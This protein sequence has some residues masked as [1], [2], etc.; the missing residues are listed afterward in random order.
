MMNGPDYSDNCPDCGEP[1]AVHR[2]V[3]PLTATRY[4]ASCNWC[5]VTDGDRQA[6]AREDWYVRNVRNREDNKIVMD[7]DDEYDGG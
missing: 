5:E 6:N 3:V 7:E 1:L 4:C 2:G